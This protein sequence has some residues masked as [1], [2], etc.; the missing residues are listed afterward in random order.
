MPIADRENM[1]LV[2]KKIVVRKN[3]YD[4]TRA[5]LVIY[6]WDRDNLV[7]VDVTDVLAP[8][9]RYE[10]RNVQDWFSD[11]V[12]GACQGSTIDVPMTGR[13]VGMPLGWNKALGSV[14]C[15]EFG[16]FTLLVL[17]TSDQ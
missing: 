2:G 7:P 15:P 4:P 13:S 16:V 3:K 17:P 11:V 8:G 12:F 14:S 1:R 6:N 10:L 5:T 9:D